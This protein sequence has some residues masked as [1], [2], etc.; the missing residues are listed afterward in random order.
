M[1]KTVTR[2]I[3]L[4][5]A[6]P[7]GNKTAFVLSG[8][9]PEDY[10]SIAKYILEETDY[11]AEQ[12]AFVKSTNAFDMSGM[13]FCGNA[14]R[15][16]A[17]MSAKGMIDGKASPE[18]RTFLEVSVS[19][20]RHPVVCGVDTESGHASASIP[21][22]KRIKT[23][24]HCD[25]KPAE[26]KTVLIM[27]GIAHLIADDIEYSEEGFDQI[28]EAMQEQFDPSALGVMYLNTK[29]LEMTPVVYVRDVDS[30]FVEGSCGSGS[31]AAAY[32]LATQTISREALIDAA[33]EKTGDTSDT[34]PQYADG[35]YE[36]E[37]KQPAGTVHASCVITDGKPS[38]LYIEGPVTLSDPEFI[39]IE[40]ESGEDEISAMTNTW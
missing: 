12:V 33:Y 9:R 32:W 8:A 39:T 19:D 4:Q 11:G 5:M 14:A 26:G 38:A 22:P 40:Y 3:L 27:E 31:A 35:T 18:S 25:F 37:L 24:K 6:D 36:Y 28:R 16:F 23:L 1:S 30:T 13:E 2:R 15:A 17:L 20:G 29:T 10:Q 21:L 7:S 34:N